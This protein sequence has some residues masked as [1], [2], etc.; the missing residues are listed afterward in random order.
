MYLGVRFIP[1]NSRA[2]HPELFT[3]PSH[4]WT[5]YESIKGASSIIYYI[6]NRSPVK[7]AKKQKYFICYLVLIRK[8][9]LFGSG[10]GEKNPDPCGIPRASE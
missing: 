3:V 7:V 4:L 9:L 5:F 1:Q 8:P 6:S 10:W 2:L